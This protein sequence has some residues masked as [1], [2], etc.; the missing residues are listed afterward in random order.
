MFILFISL[1]HLPFN[2]YR[3]LLVYNY[4]TIY[5]NKIYSFEIEPYFAL[6]NLSMSCPKK[7]NY[8]VGAAV[9]VDCSHGKAGRRV[10][11]KFIKKRKSPSSICMPLSGSTVRSGAGG[12]GG[13]VT[14]RS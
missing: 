2:N 7:I 8:P 10:S 13:R 1:S 4:H 12:G 14:P 5:V 11:N 9:V 6:F 3:I